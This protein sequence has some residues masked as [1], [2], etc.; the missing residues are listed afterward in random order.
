M[1]LQT[2]MSLRISFD[3]PYIFLSFLFLKDFFFPYFP[4]RE[5]EE[6]KQR[7]GVVGESRGEGIKSS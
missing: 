6:A 5:V 2:A 4:I 7:G 3:I 1:N